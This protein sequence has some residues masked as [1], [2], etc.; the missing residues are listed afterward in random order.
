MGSLPLR[1][2]GKPWLQDMQIL[3][4]NWSVNSSFW[5]KGT[6]FEITF[7]VLWKSLKVVAC[8]SGN[9]WKII[10]FLCLPTPTL[11]F[12]RGCK[13]ID[14]TGHKM[15]WSESEVAQSCPTLCDPV[16]CSPPGSSVHGILQAS[17]L[18]FPSPRHKMNIGANKWE[19]GDFV[20]NLF[21]NVQRSEIEW[22]LQKEWL[23]EVRE[24]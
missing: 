3:K 5:K 21:M 15:K 9:N 6:S 23:M 8:Y 7:Q 17:G 2:P 24:I 19:K 1:P 11:N 4:G 22:K 14:G 20:I 12:I 18:P 13:N 16:D 10:M